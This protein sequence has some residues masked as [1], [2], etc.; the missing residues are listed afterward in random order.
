MPKH[1]PF[2]LVAPKAPRAGE[3]LITVTKSGMPQ[4]GLFKLERRYAVYTLG[5]HA[6]PDA[7][8]ATSRP[9]EELGGT[10]SIPP[11]RQAAAYT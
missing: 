2:V 4:Q 6:I 3:K 11:N 9:T 10:P 7:W 8:V 1:K 5:G